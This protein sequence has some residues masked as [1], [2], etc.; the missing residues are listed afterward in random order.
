MYLLKVDVDTDDWVVDLNEW[1]RQTLTDWG[2]PEQW[3]IY[4]KLIIMLVVVVATVYLLQFLTNFILRFILGK[5]YK[6]TGIKLFKYT[7]ANRLPHY[8]ALVVPYSFIRGAIP[9]VFH[10]FKG[11]ISP[12]NKLTD[13]YIVFMVIWTVMS[14]LRSLGGILHEKPAFRDKPM[15]SYMQVIQINLYVL[16]A[17]A[18]YCILTNHSPAMFFAGL[19]AASAVVML[20]FKDTIMGFVSSIQLT[21]ND[22]VKLGDWITMNKY[23]ADGN[24]EE[25]NL[26]TVKVRNFDKTITTIPTYA[27]I[28]DS[29]QNWKGMQ[30]FG[31]R[32]I[33]R[34]LYVQ[35]NSI[36]FLTKEELEQY[37]KIPGLKEYIENKQAE[38]E[39]NNKDSALDLAFPE[40]SHILTNNDLFIQYGINYLGCHSGI[41]KD[42]PFLVRQ[43]PATTDGLPVEVYAFANSIDMNEYEITL[44]EIINHL[45]CAINKF[46]LVLFESSAGTDSLTVNLQK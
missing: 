30:E 35:Q 15:K 20:V 37:K 22:M 10:N 44:S 33:K 28:S 29:F 1:I 39:A 45:I 12:L 19:G 13:I 26:T 5:A 25:I 17:V 42:M 31:V 34:A 4:T 36:H 2:V 7:I 32:R 18:I 14:V 8:L 27:L 3:L 21:T 46:N 11:W 6:V 38:Y 41:N 9:V 23:G 16:G 43:L 24:V 40:E